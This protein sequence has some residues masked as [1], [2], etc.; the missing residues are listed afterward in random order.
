[1]PL[2]RLDTN[3]FDDD[4]TPA[5]PPSQE[6]RMRDQT[7]NGHDSIVDCPV[8]GRRCS[9][10]R[11]AHRQPGRRLVDRPTSLSIDLLQLSVTGNV[12]NPWW[13]ATTI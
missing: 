12:L 5:I 7:E 13:A 10:R 8:C 3:P 11:F 6:N 9:Q 4:G 1:M 2:P